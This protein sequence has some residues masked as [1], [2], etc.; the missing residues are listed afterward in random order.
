MPALNHAVRYG[1]IACQSHL[2]HATLPSSLCCDVLIWRLMWSARTFR[3][4]TA[5]VT[6]AVLKEQRRVVTAYRHYLPHGQLVRNAALFCEV[7]A[8]HEQLADVGGAHIL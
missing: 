4:P 7:V 8:R 5:L 2:V 6:D 3:W 1:C